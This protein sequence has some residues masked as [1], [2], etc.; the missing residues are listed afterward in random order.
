MARTFALIVPIWRVLQQVS[1]NSKTVPNAPKR[2]ETKQNKTWVWGPMV[3][4]VT[5]R[6]KKLWHD[7]VART[8]TLIAPVWHILHQVSCRSETVPNAPKWKAKHPNI[9]L[10]SNAMDQKSLLWK[11]LTRHHGANFCINCTSLVPFRAIAK[12]SLMLPNG[13]KD[14]KTWV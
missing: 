8:F 12:W 9:R 11:I 2:K 10:G 4:I 3:W 14:T 5:V 1:C 7:F 6:C 13:K